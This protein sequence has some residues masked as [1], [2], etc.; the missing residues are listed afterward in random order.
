MPNLTTLR[1]EIVKEFVDDAGRFL[2][3]T[4]YFRSALLCIQEATIEA[5][6]EVMPV[7][8]GHGNYHCG[9]EP[10]C[11]KNT[12]AKQHSTALSDAECKGFNACRKRILDALN[13]LRKTP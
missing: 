8:V 6:V 10:C 1:E 9:Y 3:D 2:N 13:A 5:V 11:G 4:D 7:E 12:K